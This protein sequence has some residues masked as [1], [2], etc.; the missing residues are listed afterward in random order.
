MRERFS[1]FKNQ[2]I[3]VTTDPYYWEITPSGDDLYSNL[4]MYARFSHGNIYKS[5][6]FNYLDRE[7]WKII[8]D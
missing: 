4:L 1:A 7:A 3:F 5:L 6:I 8:G 2:G